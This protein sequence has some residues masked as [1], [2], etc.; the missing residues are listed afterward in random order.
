ME[1]RAFASIATY[2]FLSSSI[3]GI[4]TNAGTWVSIQWANVKIIQSQLA[5][6]VGII[7][8]RLEH[9]SHRRSESLRKFPSKF[10]SLLFYKRMWVPPKNEPTV[11]FFPI[12]CGFSPKL[13]NIWFFPYSMWVF[14]QKMNQQLVHVGSWQ[15]YKSTGGQPAP[16]MWHLRC[17][18]E[19]RLYLSIGKSAINQ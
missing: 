19:A 10:P 3:F 15:I 8:W 13:T 12:A 18:Y 6:L 1:G 4:R 7:S 16:E 11:G 14:P 5:G 9:G 2:L 17:P